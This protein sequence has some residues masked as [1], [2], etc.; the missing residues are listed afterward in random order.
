MGLLFFP[1]DVTSTTS[2]PVHQGKYFEWPA[3]L[4]FVRL[5]STV[6][7]FLNTLQQTEQKCISAFCR[8]LEKSAGVVPRAFLG[9][10][11]EG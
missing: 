9:E 3:M 2:L 11:W 5:H 4:S 1:L 10:K 7:L 6:P 8:D